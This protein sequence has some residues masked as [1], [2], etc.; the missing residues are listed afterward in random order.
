MMSLHVT[1][2][3]LESADGP[4]VMAEIVLKAAIAARPK[5]HY[6]PGLASRLRLRRRFAAASV[7][8]AGVR[9]DLRLEASGARQE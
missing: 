5:I 6:T 2:E 7:L 3:V 8:D 4:N 1:G 9:K